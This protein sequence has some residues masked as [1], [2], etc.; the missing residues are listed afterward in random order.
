MTKEEAITLLKHA[1]DHASKGGPDA[2]VSFGIKTCE[3]I[4]TVLSAG[5]ETTAEQLAEIAR[6]NAEL[7]AR[8]VTARRSCPHCD[9]V[10]LP[11]DMRDHWRRCERHPARIAL[12]AIDSPNVITWSVMKQIA[13]V[14]LAAPAPQEER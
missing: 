3:G 9:A 13:R 10:V 7:A 6:D 1:I 8:L 14:A 11:D 2:I 5:E 12:A 4:L